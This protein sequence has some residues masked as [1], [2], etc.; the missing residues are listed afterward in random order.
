MKLKYRKNEVMKLI[1]ANFSWKELGEEHLEIW[2]SDICV[3]DCRVARA[4]F[5]GN[6]GR[7]YIDSR[8]QAVPLVNGVI[9]ECTSS[10]VGNVTYRIYRLSGKLETNTVWGLNFDYVPP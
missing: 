8:M 3:R 10:L 5:G 4:Y 6:V 2:N 7:S 9:S 1:L